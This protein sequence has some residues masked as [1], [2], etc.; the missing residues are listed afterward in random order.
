M[1]RMVKCDFYVILFQD[2]KNNLRVIWKLIKI[3]IGVNRNID[4]IKKF[5]VDGCVI[6][7]SLEMLEQFNCYF[8]FIVDKLWNQFCYVN[9]DLFKL[10][11]FVVFCKDFDVLFM[12]FV[13]ISVQ[14]SGIMMKISFYK[15]MG[16]DGISVCLLC[17]GML[18]IVFCIV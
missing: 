7:E 3:L 17:I 10:I 11:N 13:I 5:E 8:L 2:N 4:V 9:Y 1:I 16:I 12:V 18:V 6:E 15:V 14:V